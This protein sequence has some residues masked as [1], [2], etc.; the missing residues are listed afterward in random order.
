MRMSDMTILLG[1]QPAVVIA[2][3]GVD[4]STVKRAPTLLN[5]ALTVRNI[6]GANYG[7]YALVF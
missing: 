2:R 7:I 4:P 6:A 5:A 3:Y 1:K